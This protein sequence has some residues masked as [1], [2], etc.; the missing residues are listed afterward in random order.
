MPSEL[1]AV[2]VEADSATAPEFEPPSRGAAIWGEERTHS[3]PR[4]VEWLA[5]RHW[6]SPVR[7]PISNNSVQPIVDWSVGRL[8]AVSVESAESE[9]RDVS[10]RRLKARLHAAFSDE[11]LEDGASHRAETILAEALLAPP[12]ESLFDAIRTYCTGASRPSFAAETLR[13]LGRLTAPGTADWRLAL[14]RD[15]LGSPDIEIRDAALQ[16]VEG[17]EDAALVPVLKSHR[18]SEEWLR[19]YLH[20][21][22]RYL[23]K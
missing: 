7:V 8:I 5:R 15:A 1:T 18:E 10:W 3:W 13:C 21:V 23:D 19:D 9:E 4:V 14:V 17:W 2:A 20:E 16:A 11:P 6:L 12:G 22:L